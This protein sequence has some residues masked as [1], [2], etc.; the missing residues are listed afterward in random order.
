M[1]CTSCGREIAES[2]NFCRY[3]GAARPVELVPEAQEVSPPPE[4]D[5]ATPDNAVQLH[6]AILALQSQVGHLSA[7]VAALETA[8]V[9]ATS[10]QPTA[11]VP[12]SPASPAVSISPGPSLAPTI[13]GA[14]VGAVSPAAAQPTGQGGN[15]SASPPGPPAQAGRPMNWEWLVGGNW[16]ARIGILAVIIGVGFFLKLAFDNQWIGETGRVVLGLVIGLALLGAGEFWSRKYAVWSQAVTGGGIAILYLS[17]FAAFSLYGLIPAWPALGFSLLVTL[18]AAGLALRYEARAIA[19][20]GILGGF[21][22]P[23]FLADKLPQQA[24]LLAYVLVLDAG[25]LALATFRNWRWFTLLALVGSLVLFMFWRVELDPTVA[26]SQVGITVIFLIFVGATTLF[27]LIWRRPPQV[28]DQALIVLNAAA[29]MGLTYWLLWDDF[30]VW[31][32]GFTL[33][34]AVFYGLLAYGILMRHREQVNLSMFSVGVALVLLSIAVPVQLSGSWVGPAW[35]IEGAVLVWVSFFIRMPQLRWFAVAA[36]AVTL[37]WLL[38]IDLPG[39]FGVY[40]YMGWD[41]GTEWPVVNTYFLS[42]VMIIAAAYVSAFFWWKNRGE[43]PYEWEAF[44]PPALVVAANLLTLWALSV[45]VDEAVYLWVQGPDTPNYVVRNTTSLSLSGLWTVYAAV[46]IVL[47]IW[48]QQ[49]WLRLGGLV[50]LAIPVLKLFLYDSFELDQGYRVAAFIG[51][52][53]LLLAGGFLYQR[54]SRA[55]RGFLLE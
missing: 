54:Y 53:A 9:P 19:I 29:Y 10:S 38:V 7:R 35:A 3:C 43:T 50:L 48:K 8:A 55:I 40:S 26:L 39:H 28:F 5:P 20:L 33:L 37:G 18:A 32:G 46:L 24:A 15:I 51:L 17:V 49:R 2:A 12:P 45:Q 21:A 27:H 52:G 22:T 30:R 41:A 47:G 13:P 4:V 14:Q 44:A 1:L 16:L 6:A 31:M 34:L 11:S 42:H 23:L 25:V 36:F